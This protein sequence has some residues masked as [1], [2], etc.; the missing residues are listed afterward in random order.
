MSR[1]PR[2]LPIAGISILVLAAAAVISTSGESEPERSETVAPGTALVSLQEEAGV[3]QNDYKIYLRPRDIAIFTF[4]TYRAERSLQ[5]LHAALGKFSPHVELM[6]VRVN[7]LESVA[8]K[9][10]TYPGLLC[11][12]RW[13]A[14]GFG[15]TQPLRGFEV[16]AGESFAVTAWL[17]VNE[18]ADLTVESLN[19]VYRSADTDYEQVLDNS[20]L[21]L[22]VT[23]E[24]AAP[25][26][27]KLCDPTTGEPWDEAAS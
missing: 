8:G 13:P 10:V 12:R 19:I 5:M 4:G 21:R 18:P 16:A 9:P 6:A 2:F 25:I 23:D 20:S 14:R 27:G 22:S 1:A 7:R 3:I 11:T 17:R 26:S 24:S 15:P